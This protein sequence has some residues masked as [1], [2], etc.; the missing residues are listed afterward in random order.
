MYSFAIGCSLS[1]FNSNVDAIV[2]GRS[3]LVN[4]R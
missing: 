4:T 3:W 1:C 2:R